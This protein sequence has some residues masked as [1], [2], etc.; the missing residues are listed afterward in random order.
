VR[1]PQLRGPRLVAAPAWLAAAVLAAVALSAAPP[2]PAGA[3]PRRRAGK[4][5]RIDRPRMRAAERVRVCSL[6]NPEGRRMT[7]L[8]GSP[9]EPGTRFGLVDDLGLRGHGLA[10]RA[11]ASGQDY[12]KNGSAHE[13]EL[14][15]EEPRGLEPRPGPGSP[16]TLAVQGVPLDEG[17][18]LVLDQQLR[19]SGREV[20]QVWMAVDRDGDGDADLAVTAFECSDQ[21]RDLPLAAS[22]Q[23]VSPYCLDYWLRDGAQWSKVE[24]YVFFNCL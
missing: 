14:T 24:R 22:G 9:P 20:E 1:T 10:V 12:C 5:V 2:S 15:Y 6:T 23:R 19:P 8:G 13:V 17:A 4:I 16:F 7:C 18:R 21:V 3:E 11:Q